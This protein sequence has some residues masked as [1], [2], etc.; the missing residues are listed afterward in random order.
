MDKLIKH[1]IKNKHYNGHRLYRN[2]D[3][4]NPYNLGPGVVRV[5][6]LNPG[7]GYDPN[8]EME[9]FGEWINIEGDVWD[10]HPNVG[11]Q[12]LMDRFANLSKDFNLLGVNFQGYTGDIWATFRNSF[13]REING[14]LDL[15]GVDCN[16]MFESSKL[17]RVNGTIIVD[18]SCVYMFRECSL[19]Q[20]I[21][22]IEFKNPDVRF[23]GMFMNDRQVVGGILDFYNKYI[24]YPNYQECLR[25]CGEDTPTGSQ[26]LALIPD[27]WK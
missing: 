10:F 1:H 23:Q 11:S 14:N 27:D 19:L 7:T 21:P 20:W 2:I 24:Q 8:T 17:E 4:F 13:I 5:Q 9:F 3:E 12:G 18:G 15:R 25:N 6:F 22:D 26:E 16:E